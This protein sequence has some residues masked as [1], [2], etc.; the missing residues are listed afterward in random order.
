MCLNKNPIIKEISTWL[1]IYNFAYCETSSKFLEYLT[2]ETCKKLLG[3]KLLQQYLHTHFILISNPFSRNSSCY[4]QLLITCCNLCRFD[5]NLGWFNFSMLLTLDVID[6]CQS[7][8]ISTKE[9]SYRKKIYGFYN[10]EHAYAE[11]QSH[12]PTSRGWNSK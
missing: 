9:K 10:W 5:H 11:S 4:T 1:K 7:R 12:N 8:T 3:I 2:S 6:C